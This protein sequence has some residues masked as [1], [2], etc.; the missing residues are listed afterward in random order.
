MCMRVISIYLFRYT[1]TY[2]YLNILIDIYIYLSR[3]TFTFSAY[4]QQEL[5]QASETREFDLHAYYFHQD[6][7]QL[8]FPG[9]KIYHLKQ[10]SSDDLPVDFL[11]RI[12]KDRFR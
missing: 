6:N 1:F 3:Y 2:I 11:Y 4:N 8:V 5:F 10:I 7:S 12:N 9:T